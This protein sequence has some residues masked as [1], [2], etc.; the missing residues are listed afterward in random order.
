MIQISLNG[1]TKE[2]TSP[3]PLQQALEHW[4]YGQEKIAAAVNGEFIPR[5]TYSDCLL[6]TGDQIDVVKPIGGG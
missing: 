1:E 5:S 3:I 6:K 2:L 4:G